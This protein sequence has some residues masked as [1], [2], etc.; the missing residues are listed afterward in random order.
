VTAAVEFVAPP[1]ARAAY[2]AWAAAGVLEAASTDLVTRVGGGY[3]LWLQPGIATAKGRCRVCRRNV[4]INVAGAGRHKAADPTRFCDGS[5]LRTMTRA[6]VAAADGPVPDPAAD[7][8]AGQPGETAAASLRMVPLDRLVPHAWNPRREVGNT[9]E[10]AA[11]IRTIGVLEP[12]VVAPSTETADRWVVIAGHRRVRAAGQ[13][14]LA[15]IPAVVRADLNTPARQLEAMLIEN[16]HRLDLTP[17]EE[18][19]GYQQ[20]RLEFG[21]APRDIAAAVGRTRALVDRRLALMKLPLPTREKVHGGQLSLGDAEA[22][23]EFTG[24]PKVLRRLADQAGTLNFAFAVQQARQDRQ[25]A[26]QLRRLITAARADGVTVLT[27]PPDRWQWSPAADGRPYPLDRL[28]DEPT[29]EEHAA[30]CG[31]HVLVPVPGTGELVACCLQPSAHLQ[32]QAAAAA[33]AGTADGGDDGPAGGDDGAEAERRLA[34]ARQ[35]EA[36]LEA[37]AAVRS[38]FTAGLLKPGYRPPADMRA[39]MLRHAV[40]AW[41]RYDGGELAAEA[42]EALGLGPPGPDGDGEPTQG[43][44]ADQLLDRVRTS[45][46]ERLVQ[47]VYALLV[48]PHAPPGRAAHEWRPG[49]RYGMPIA[50][51]LRWLEKLGYQPCDVEQRMLAEAEARTCRACG[52]TDDRACEGGCEWI[53]GRAAA[54]QLC[55]RCATK[56]DPT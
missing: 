51:H 9:D 25:R 52:C 15:E 53:A 37:A 14:E 42:W 43:D 40:T 34:A 55:S 47:A 26:A 22:M 16:G 56:E 44:L 23:A 28:E 36:E 29:A 39:M 11:S 20:L 27:N 24:D 33:A 48:L 45:P 46:L 17:V 19:E 18:A 41:I 5:G 6:E 31:H 30:G 1:D 50:E 8:P 35:L 4:K 10:L 13:A 2:E 21:Y 49:S 7:E 12:V 3:D 38:E 32:G 54:D